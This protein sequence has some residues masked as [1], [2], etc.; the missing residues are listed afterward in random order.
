VT[1]FLTFSSPC[2]SLKS[3]AGILSANEGSFPL[4]SSPANWGKISQLEDCGNRF[5]SKLFKRNNP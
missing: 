2:K 4:K 1:V 3:G 5:K